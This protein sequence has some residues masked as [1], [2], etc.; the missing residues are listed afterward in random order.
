VV[1]HVLSFDARPLSMQILLECGRA[2]FSWKTAYDETFRDFSPGMLLF[3]D[4]TAALLADPTIAYADSRA[5]DDRSFMA[6]T[7]KQTIADLW[8]DVA[9]R[10]WNDA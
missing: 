5:Y 1:I 10:D 6:W 9:P 8:F 7:E 2:A 3:E 4:Y